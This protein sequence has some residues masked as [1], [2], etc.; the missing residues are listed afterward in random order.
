MLNPHV[1]IAEAVDL[2]LKTS[3]VC[4]DNH[5]YL[6]QWCLTLQQLLS[7]LDALLQCLIYD[8]S[9]LLV[10]L[11][12]GVHRRC[13]HGTGETCLNEPENARPFAAANR[14]APAAHSNRG[15]YSVLRYR[16]C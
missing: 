16:R 8:K 9:V 10:L 3:F 13:K 11:R 14:L 1:S 12:I 15:L 2:L 4:V 7:R 6:I 5:I